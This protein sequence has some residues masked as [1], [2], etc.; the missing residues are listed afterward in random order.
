MYQFFDKYKN[1]LIEA[2]NSVS[3]ENLEN[4][5]ES[6]LYSYRNDKKVIILGNGGSAA[7]ASHFTC[8]LG[9]GTN[10]EGLKRFKVISLT[11]NLPLI[12][13]ISN[14]L[15]YDEVF[16]YQLENILEEDDLVIGI[17]ASGNSENVV[18]AFE[19]AK[20]KSAR[21]YGLIG[22]TG[23]R[24]KNLSDKYIYINSFNYG[25]VEDIHLILVHIITQYIKNHMLSLKNLDN[26]ITHYEDCYE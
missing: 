12:T 10:V 14:D 2:I 23:G 20:R 4:F 5:S 17:S 19:F 6:L 3:N 16:K 25:V 21:T 15:S 18:R 11:D 1:D 7:T 26:D 9:K 22:F 8:D 24:L 13:A